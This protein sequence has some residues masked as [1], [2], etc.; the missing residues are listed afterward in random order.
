MV[1]P[2]KDA[3]WRPIQESVFQKIKDIFLI[4]N[5]EEE[6]KVLPKRTYAQVKA[7]FKDTI[8]ILLQNLPEDDL[9]EILG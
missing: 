5:E 8:S 9:G 3:N 2:D 1:L 7:I 4:Y 6:Q